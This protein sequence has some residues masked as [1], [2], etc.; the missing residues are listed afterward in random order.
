[1]TQPPDQWYTFYLLKE[2]PEIEKGP[3][4]LWIQLESP[5]VVHLCLGCVFCQCSQVVQGTGMAWIEPE[6]L[7][8]LSD[9][10]SKTS[11]LGAMC[12]LSPPPPQI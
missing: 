7:E 5:L 3:V 4:V 9:D 8:I 11:K 2:I 6:K 12:L 1:M 10:C